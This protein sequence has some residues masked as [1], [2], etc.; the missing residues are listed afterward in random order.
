MAWYFWMVKWVPLI[1][2]VLCALGTAY[3][4]YSMFSEV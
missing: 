4:I 2:I 3:M 1:V